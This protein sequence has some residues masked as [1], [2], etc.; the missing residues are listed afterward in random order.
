M[1]IKRFKQCQETSANRLKK[2]KLLE[3]TVARR[4]EKIAELQATPTTQSPRR[5]SGKYVVPQLTVAA[6][7]LVRSVDR[8]YGRAT[9]H[10]AAGTTYEEDGIYIDPARANCNGHL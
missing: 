4:N 7:Q 6:K 9:G 10:D 3:Q 2:L 8:R 1:L 5:V